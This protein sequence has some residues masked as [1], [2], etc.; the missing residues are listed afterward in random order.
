MNRPTIEALRAELDTA[1]VA[2]G[3]AITAPDREAAKLRVRR[4]TEAIER[5]ESR[6][7]CGR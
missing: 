7:E 4:A 6:I 5:H 3:R 2:Y 1:M